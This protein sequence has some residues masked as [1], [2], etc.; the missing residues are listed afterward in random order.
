MRIFLRDEVGL[1][2][3]L[4]IFCEKYRSMA[5]F[6]K[7]KI[8][9]V[10]RE[11]DEAVSISFHLPDALKEDF[12]FIQGQYL[13]LKALIDGEE[14]RRSYSICSSP[15]DEE[16]RVAVKQI[17]SGKFSTYANTQLK[18]G[19]ELEVMS[20]LGNFYTEIDASQQKSYAAFAAGSGI[21]PILSIIKATLTKETNSEFHLF[22]GNKTTDSVIFREELVV[23]EAAYSGRLHIHHILSRDAEVEEKFRGRLSAEKLKGYHQDLMDVSK[24][25][26]VFLCGPEAMIFELKETL[27]ALGLPESSIHFELFTSAQSNKVDDATQTDGAVNSQVEVI[28]YGES[29][30]FE[31]SEDGDSILD[32]AMAAD[33]DAPFA[34]KGGVCCACKAKVLEGSVKMDANF[35]LDQSEVDEGYILTCQSHPT[36]KKLVIDFDDF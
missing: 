11:T 23:L 5:H 29:F 32:A 7:L 20:P 28:V 8:E 33:A 17:P 34:C 6:Q 4:S 35:A 15:F 22:Y 14:V 25:D 10:K 31:L 21:T 36:S 19:D 12:T 13:T 9:E 16:L 1:N 26:E 3:E 18:V 30:H 24:L 27:E 2:R